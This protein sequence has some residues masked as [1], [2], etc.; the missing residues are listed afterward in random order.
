MGNTHFLRANPQF[1][2]LIL[3]AGW[4]LLVLVGILA[5]P[6]IARAQFCPRGF[7]D[8]R[9]GGECWECP[10]GFNRTVF[11]VTAG[12]ACEVAR[13]ATFSAA[14]KQGRADCEPGDI[15]DPI[16]GGTCWRCGA[17]RI[18]T[19]FPVNGGQACGLPGHL[20]G[21]Q[22]ATFI[23]RVGCTAPAFP[24]IGW[25]WTCPAGSGRDIAPITSDRACVVPAKTESRAATF[26]S[27]AACGRL[28][29]RAC[30]IVGRNSC[31]ADLVEFDNTCRTR[32]DCGTDG[33][34]R[35]L[36]G[37]PGTWEALTGCAKTLVPVNNICTHP[38]CGRL[39]EKACAI[40]GRPSCDPDL[41]EFDNTCKKR[42]DCGTQGK[43]R[44]LAGEPGKWEPLTG[45]ATTLVPEK[46]ICTR[47]DCGR[48]DEKACAISGR[49][50]CDQGLVEFDNVC[51]T[52]GDC[53]AEGQRPCL[54]GEPRPGCSIGLSDRFGRCHTC[55]GLGQWAC[56]VPGRNSCNGGL[57][58]V[59]DLCF[60]RGA[61]G[62]AE[63]RACLVGERSNPGCDSGSFNGGGMCIKCG[64]NGERACAIPGRASCDKGLV[65]FKDMCFPKGQCGAA[66]QRV[67]LIG[68]SARAGCAANLTAQD[69]VCITPVA[70]PPPLPGPLFAFVR[71]D[72]PAP[73]LTPSVSVF[74][75]ASAHD[76]TTKASLTG[77]NVVDTIEIFQAGYAGPGSTAPVLVKTC[78]K[79][80]DCRFPLPASAS[81]S[82]SYKARIV[83]GGDS[84]T[85]PIRV[86]DLK[87]TVS[88][89]R[90]NVSAEEVGGNKIALVPYKRTIDIVFYAG[91]GYTSYPLVTI[92][93]PNAFSTR[94]A[95]ELSTML[96]VAN[97]QRTSLADN[98][99]AVSFYASPA[100]AV[101]KRGDGLIGMCEHS[102]SGPIAW[103]DAQGI[104]HPALPP[105]HENC[106]D[107]SVPGPFYSA[108]DAHTSWHEMHHAAFQMSDEYC[109]GTIHSQKVKF[110]NVY[111]SQ[112]ECISKSSSAA[113]CVRIQTCVGTSCS[114]STRYWRSDPANDVMQNGATEQAD[115]VRAT[116]GKFDE[117]TAGGC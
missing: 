32:G 67:C 84:F 114:C 6:S 18:R 34:R 80:A 31:D 79:Q 10:S 102:T 90:I 94:L 33:K 54:V 56:S 95:E 65:E 112:A 2:A 3:C 111:S 73:A 85:T 51:R 30:A 110:P 113:T 45:C 71:T 20:T 98:L 106:R 58:E 117:C 52:R 97:R 47:P 46:N 19:I 60:T 28:N 108:R 78:R 35:C 38:P 5:W 103:G 17:G 69:G 12:N 70:V 41:V 7:L 50:T 101:V 107:W 40:A 59:N 109:E 86:T 77:V 1:R 13:P 16:N 4:S 57:V 24:D 68:E 53:G 27:R 89:V 82:T 37:E 49:P 91:S 11:P 55:G 81:R 116:N 21:H 61:C 29:E 93:A 96:G 23:K 43:R 87:F 26:I 25:C 105:P 66:R 115:D 9:N 75:V 83:R 15:F 99:N 92:A 62:T 8:P 42:G 72:P 36:A 14:N 64:A 44:C 39:E 74:I 76:G 88:P 63:Q 104:L 100:P 22:P 48:L